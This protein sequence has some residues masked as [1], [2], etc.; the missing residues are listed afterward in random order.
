[1]ALKIKKGDK[2]L[3]ISGKDKG[4]VGKVIRSF[5]KEGKVLVEGV[6]LIKKHVRAKREGE[7]GKILTMEAPIHVSKLKLLCPLCQKATRVGFL[8]EGKEKFRFCK[9]CKGKFK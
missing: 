2:V 8:I 9:K 5:P 3:V 1:M 7:K 4:K 6:N